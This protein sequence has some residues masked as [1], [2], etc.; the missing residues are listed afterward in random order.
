[1]TKAKDVMD[2]GRT[3]T[4]RNTEMGRRWGIGVTLHL[5]ET[6]SALFVDND[7]SYSLY[8]PEQVQRE[9]EVPEYLIPITTVAVLLKN[10]DKRFLNYL[11]QRWNELK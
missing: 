7:G 3:E 6:Q 11:K 1:M 4:Y 9:A 2:E 10:R 8:V 5:K